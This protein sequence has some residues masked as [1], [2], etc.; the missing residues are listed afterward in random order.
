MSLMSRIES[1]CIAKYQ[2]FRRDFVGI[3]RLNVV[4]L[5]RNGP[6]LRTKS[7]FWPFPLYKQNRSRTDLLKM[8][9][10]TCETLV[11]TM[12]LTVTIGNYFFPWYPLFYCKQG[13]NPIKM[14]NIK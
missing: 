5:H 6:T 3:V 12:R 9:T 13:T 7:R 14:K 11:P 4:K 10:K 2:E 8:R 1:V